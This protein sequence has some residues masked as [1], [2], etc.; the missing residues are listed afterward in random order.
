MEGTGMKKC[1]DLECIAKGLVCT[2]VDTLMNDSIS[3]SMEML[4]LYGKQWIQG[5]FRVFY[6]ERI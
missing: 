1:N 5:A 3:L 4:S 6:R 2:R